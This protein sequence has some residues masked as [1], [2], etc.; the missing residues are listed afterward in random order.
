MLLLLS[1]LLLS[2]KSHLQNINHQDVP[3]RRNSQ[4]LAC[5]DSPFS[6]PPF[7][8]VPR[9]LWVD[10]KGL[11]LNFNL[12]S[13]CIGALALEPSHFLSIYWTLVFS[14]VLDT[15]PARL[16]PKWLLLFLKRFRMTT[17]LTVPLLIYPTMK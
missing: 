14:L 7:S 2:S 5:P 10:S 6:N 13:K 1:S 8:S 3:C 15:Y 16:L 4:N 17:D 9:V 11:V 12:S